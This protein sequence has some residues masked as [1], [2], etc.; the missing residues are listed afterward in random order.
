M[1][2]LTR[3][4]AIRDLREELRKRVDEDHSLCQVAAQERIFC[5]GFSQWTFA[6]LKALYPWITRSRPKLTRAELEDLANRWQL[7]RQFVFDT[8]LS[9]DAQCREQDVHGGYLE[10]CGGWNHFSDEE[11]ARFHAQI[12]GEEIDLQRP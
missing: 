12:C 2:T 11:I 9:C 3:E 6:E 1:N 5:T 8:E 4:E 10:V 7:A